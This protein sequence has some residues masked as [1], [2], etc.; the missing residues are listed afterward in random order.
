MMFFGALT[1]CSKLGFS[2]SP[3]SRFTTP[4]TF[5]IVGEPP[6]QIVNQSKK[7]QADRGD[8]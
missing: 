2:T 6:K 8:E 5:L 7:R 3:A 4:M 1:C